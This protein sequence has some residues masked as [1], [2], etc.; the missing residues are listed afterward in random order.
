MGR[1]SKYLDVLQR[2]VEIMSTPSPGDLLLLSRE[3]QA[4]IVRAVVQANNQHLS[5]ISIKYQ[6][7]DCTPGNLKDTY[8]QANFRSLSEVVSHVFE[9]N[10]LEWLFFGHPFPKESYFQLVDHKIKCGIKQNELDRI[11]DPTD[12]GTG[13]SRLLVRDWLDRGNTFQKSMLL[14][15][16]LERVALCFGCL[17][18]VI[19][20]GVVCC[21][22]GKAFCIP[23]INKQEFCLNGECDRTDRDVVLIT[24]NSPNSTIR[25]L[26]ER[27]MTVEVQW[28]PG[29]T[30]A[31]SPVEGSLRDCMTNMQAIPHHILQTP[32]TRLAQ[33]QKMYQILSKL[34][35][36]PPDY[37]PIPKLL[38]FEDCR[39]VL[40]DFKA[41]FLDKGVEYLSGYRD[42]CASDFKPSSLWTDVMSALHKRTRFAYDISKVIRGDYVRFRCDNII[43]LVNYRAVD[44]GRRRLL[45]S[46]DSTNYPSKEMYH[47]VDDLD[48]DDRISVVVVGV[49]LHRLRPDD[50]P[51]A[52]VWSAQHASY[53]FIPSI[54]LF[55]ESWG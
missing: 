40:A 7:P 36:A 39:D 43:G 55:E 33:G 52:E 12:D 28:T 44:W 20:P 4:A 16:R 30:G 49:N 18:N 50:Y 54:C 10:N 27:L 47:H 3:Q 22:C 1:N 35:S 21:R 29:S 48:D 24:P 46:W 31:M 42:L 9:P 25:Q 15:S 6:S 32:R 19:M 8:E 2:Q 23:C 41:G 38:P 11:C 14:D 13:S 26:H 5:T 37:E 45:C 51:W 53:Q 34:S 17:L